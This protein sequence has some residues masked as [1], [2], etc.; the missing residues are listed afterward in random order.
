M[1]L[2]FLTLSAAVILASCGGAEE[3]EDKTHEDEANVEQV[4][5]SAPAGPYSIDIKVDVSSIK[6]KIAA[7]ANT[8]KLSKQHGMAIADQLFREKLDFIDLDAFI[9][10]V[11]EFESTPTLVWSKEQARGTAQRLG[12]ATQGAFHTLQGKDKED[13]M[14]ALT[15]I[16][17]AGMVKSQAIPQLDLKE[18]E[19]GMRTYW[20][21]KT[22][23]DQKDMEAYSTYLQEFYKSIGSQFLSENGQRPEVKTTASGLQYQVLREG[24]G[25]PPTAGS[26]VTV[27]YH[28]VLVDGTKF[29]S[30]YDRGE[31]T[32]FGVTQVIPGWTEGLQLMNQGSKF[33]FYIPYNLAY[34]D[35]G[36]PGIPPYSTLIFDVELISFK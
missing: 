27:H 11:Q 14:M 1:K 34:G 21:D 7:S 6:E 23:K 29:D 35:R 12:Q 16:F 25:A 22:I 2:Q 30:S 26:T 3:Q 36:T 24:A 5:P 33:R 9:A 18:F 19:T 10:K 20:K 8:L 32:S 15:S 28:G 31:P 4:V 13:F 17:Y